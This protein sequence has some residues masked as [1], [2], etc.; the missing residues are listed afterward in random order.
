MIMHSWSR[1]SRYFLLTLVLAILVWFIVAARALIG[2]LVISALLAYVLN[3]A[4]VFFNK[5]A[6][7]PRKWVVLF[8]YLVSLAIIITLAVVFA[9]IIPDQVASLITELQKILIQIEEPLSRPIAFFG[10]QLAFDNLLANPEVLSADFIRPDLILE[11]AR[12]ASENLAW[13]LVILVTTY[14][15]MQDWPRLRD[16]LLDLSPPFI[17]DDARRLYDEISS[18]WQK[19]LVGQLRLMI[20]IGL[21]TGVVSAVVGLPGAAA[22]GVLAGLLDIILTVGPTIAMIIAGLVAYFAGSTY[23]PISNTWFM[24]LVAALFLAI[25]LFEDVWLRPRIMGHTLKMHPA[26][27]FIAIMGA[28][29]MAGILVALIIIPVVA[30]VGIIGHYLY[31]RIL[32]IEPWPEDIAPEINTITEA[33]PPPDKV[34]LET[35]Q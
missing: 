12:S 7:L 19:Y 6:K 17:A 21:V 27:V 16:W 24:I 8:V 34:R 2:P 26:V 13:L 18:I 11:I 1:T 20:T 35:G 5:Q 3:P 22:F 10:F 32:E 30:S 4:V 14:Y 23:L 28:L 31:C 33:L 15:I 25:K 29:A 9:P